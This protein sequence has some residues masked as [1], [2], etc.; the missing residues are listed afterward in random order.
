MDDLIAFSC[1]GNRR[2]ALVH[3][4]R[5]K[6]VSFIEKEIAEFG[7]T[8]PVAFARIAANTGSARPANC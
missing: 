8:E 1:F 7:L 6:P 5:A 2:V 3:G 4:D